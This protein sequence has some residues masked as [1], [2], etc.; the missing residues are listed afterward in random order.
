MNIPIKSYSILGCS[1][2]SNGDMLEF[3]F[4]DIHRWDFDPYFGILYIFDKNLLDHEWL[5][6][7]LLI[8][9]IKPLHNILFSLPYSVISMPFGAERRK[10]LFNPALR[11]EGIGRR[12]PHEVWISPDRLRVDKDIQ[13]LIKRDMLVKTKLP[14]LFVINGEL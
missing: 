12:Y 4:G 5:I 2:E 11:F 8:G 14:N 1:D 13:L 3:A 7:Q 10:L 9:H 6:L